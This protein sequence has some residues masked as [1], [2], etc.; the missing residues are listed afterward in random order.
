MDAAQSLLFYFFIHQNPP[1]LP[2]TPLYHFN[3]PFLPGLVSARAF[4]FY[5]ILLHFTSSLYVLDTCI[6]RVAMH[7]YVTVFNM[8]Y[9]RMYVCRAFE[10]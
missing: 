4:S 8:I 5:F 2:F 6:L 3:S 9:A 7:I 10:E 1:C